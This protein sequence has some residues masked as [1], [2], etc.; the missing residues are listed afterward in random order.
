MQKILEG[1]I[2]LVR[3]SQKADGYVFSECFGVMSSNFEN[4]KNQEIRRNKGDILI[5]MELPYYISNTAC[6]SL[7]LFPV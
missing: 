5:C 4:S 6:L 1:L 7:S 3:Y 2:N